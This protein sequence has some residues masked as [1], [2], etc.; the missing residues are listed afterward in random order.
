MSTLK[1][2]KTAKTSTE[3][4]KVAAGHTDEAAL[5]YIALRDFKG[6]EH[7]LKPFDEA[8]QRFVKNRQEVLWDCLRIAVEDA[9]DKK[10]GTFLRNFAEAIERGGGENKLL[11]FVAQ[12]IMFLQGSREPIPTAEL[13][14][15]WYLAQT[16]LSDG[17]SRQLTAFSRNIERYY[18]TLGC[19][20]S[21]GAAN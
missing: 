5:L 18:K 14:A 6:F 2:V 7:G 1:K 20:S 17:T 19:Q 11:R 9:M 16:G 13:M 4:L 21:Q 15:R 3:K 8:V 12:S 10:N